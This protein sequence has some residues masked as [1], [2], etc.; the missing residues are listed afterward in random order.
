MNGPDIHT[1]LPGPAGAAILDALNRV[2]YPGLTK[3]LGPFVIR[4]KDG[5]W[6]ED[7][8]GNVF[9][10]LISGMASVPLGAAN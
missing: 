8:D 7:V 4:R 10:D 3:D 1:G 6:I 5:S 2:L 9:L